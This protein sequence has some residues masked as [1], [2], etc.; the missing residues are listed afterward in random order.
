VQESELPA[1]VTHLLLQG[2]QDLPLM[3]VPSRQLVHIK[4]LSDVQAAQ[5]GA[6]MMHKLMELSKAYPLRQLVQTPEL[7][8]PH[9]GVHKIIC[10]L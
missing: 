9:P 2:R 5:P 3:Y 6:Q 4:G 7:H 1:Q 8:S 10:P